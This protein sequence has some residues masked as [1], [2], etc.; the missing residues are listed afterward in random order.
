[1]FAVREL[2]IALSQHDELVAKVDLT[3]DRAQQMS[4]ANS[5]RSAPRIH[6]EL[7]ILGIDVAHS[8]VAKYIVPRSRRPLPNIP[9]QSKKERP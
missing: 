5:L 8:T 4:I 3:I 7:L 1:M 2:I 9:L 6:R